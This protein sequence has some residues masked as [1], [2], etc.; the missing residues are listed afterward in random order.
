MTARFPTASHGS[1]AGPRPTSR[2]AVDARS[3]DRKTAAWQRRRWRPEALIATGAALLLVLGI[4]ITVTVV[5]GGH[6]SWNPLFTVALCLNP[7]VQGF[8]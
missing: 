5:S 2:C 8:A 3:T 7:I 4:V 6:V 1:R